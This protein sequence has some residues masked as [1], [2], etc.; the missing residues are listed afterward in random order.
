MPWTAASTPTLYTPPAAAPI[1]PAPPAPL[2]AQWPA[3]RGRHQLAAAGRYR[4]FGVA[5]YRFYRSTTPP[6]E[7]TIHSGKRSFAS[8]SFAAWSFASLSQAGAQPGVIWDTNATL[9]HTPADTFADDVW[10]L[11]VSYFNGAIDSGFL[12]I[13]PAG[14][15]Y[16]RMD[17]S[18]G[19]ATGTPPIAPQEFRIEQSAGGVVRVIGLYLQIDADRAGQW[20]IA[21]TTDGSDPPSDTP[22]LTE[23]MPA[24]GIA[25]LVYNL[26]A[27]SHGATVKVRLQTRRLDS[28]WV[29]SANSTIQQTTADAQG[30]A[31]PPTVEDWPGRLPE[32]Q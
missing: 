19:V 14:E 15:T 11:A 7:Q 9:P 3:F 17:I 5:G 10:Y 22:D 2:S 13:G 25:M 21:Y 26:P 31:A 30:P 12:P 29:Y 8:W 18:G 32:N 6:P 27:A 16:L 24:S 4:V 20:A 28:A 23:A 1:A